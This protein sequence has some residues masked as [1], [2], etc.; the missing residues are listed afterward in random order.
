MHIPV[1]EYI[2][3]DATVQNIWVS[4]INMSVTQNSPVSITRM[5]LLQKRVVIAKNDLQ[6][7]IT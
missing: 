3:G 1:R 7:I 5:F 6:M 2:E 4:N